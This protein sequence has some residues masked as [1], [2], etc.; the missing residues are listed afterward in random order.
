MAQKMGDSLL[1]GKT[2]EVDPLTTK[3][4][5][6]RNI[7][8]MDQLDENERDSSDG[9]LH[10]DEMFHSDEEEHQIL[11]EIRPN[12]VMLSWSPDFSSLVERLSPFP[13]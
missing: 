5:D 1:Q 9:D 13:D 10:G 11:A 3:K 7:K 12:R 4:P 8:N 2:H 6:Q